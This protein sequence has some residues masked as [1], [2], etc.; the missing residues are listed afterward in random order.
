MKRGL[1]ICNQF[2][3][4]TP[5]EEAFLYPLCAMAWLKKRS[6]GWPG[7]IDFPSGPVTLHYFLPVI[8]ALASKI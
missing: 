2:M 8:F 1:L 7:Q 6:S 5:R 4:P 3:L